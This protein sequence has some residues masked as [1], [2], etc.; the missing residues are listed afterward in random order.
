MGLHELT[1]RN[2]R[3]FDELV[4]TPDPRA[5]TVL[6]SPNGSGKTT[7]LEA[8]CVLATG[9]SFRTPSASDLIRTGS[10]LAEVHGVM[11]QG[12]RRVAIDLTV[13]RGARATTKRMLV[14]GLR[15]ASRAAV[16]EVLPLTVF[17]PE[18]IDIV[19]HGAEHRRA[20]L[21]TL[22][23]DVDLASGDVIERFARVLTQRNALLRSL[24][25]AAPTATQRDE[26]D[27]WTTDVAR[28]GERL[29]A[30]R[31]AVV[32]SLEPLVATFYEELAHDGQATGLRYERSWTGDLATALRST[33]GED[34]RRGYTTLGPQRDDLA[35]TLGG[36]DARR[37]ASQGEQRTLALALRLA[38]HHLVQRERSLDPLLLL[39]DVFSELDPLR[40]DRLL[41]LLPR[42]QTLVT[43]ASPLP[44]GMHPA[45]VVDL[46]NPS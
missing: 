12:E 46:T 11:T 9:G 43:T 36:R 26:L 25:G 44:A 40:A 10:D 1:V 3:L 27:V 35:L 28:E 29:V 42:G 16:A 24:Q 34:W 19:R 31:E 7:V 6:L 2:F 20:Y 30:R 33:T 4:F 38:G 18:G 5:V 39:D 23:T 13:T 17:T 37:Q 15:P 45:V 14:N 41:H 21:T 8:V 22:L 32:A